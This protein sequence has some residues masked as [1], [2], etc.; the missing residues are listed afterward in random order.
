MGKRKPRYNYNTTR[1]PL[2][3]PEYGR[4]IQDMVNHL[5]TIPDRE[6]RNKAAHTLIAIMQ[7]MMPQREMNGDFKHKLWD[8]LAIMADFELDID[9]PYELPTQEK[10]AEK[11]RRVPYTSSNI[12]FKHYGHLTEELISIASGM[13]EGN[14]KEVLIRMIAN[15]MKRQFLTWN[16]QQV[17]D[18]T[19]FNDMTVLS[20]GK[21]KIPET[22][23][24][25]ENKDL[26]GKK[27]KK[28]Y[29]KK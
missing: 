20:G 14:E 18:E 12:R 8:H 23:T 16:R 6:T 11:P 15:H 28:N 3:M 9:A 26:I 29:R 2:K 1:E 5:K 17:T 7:N 19:I 24:L 10:M 27:K 4:H 13:P 21:L 22:L 25:Q